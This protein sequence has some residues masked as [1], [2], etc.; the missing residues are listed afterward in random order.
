MVGG[1]LSAIVP[2][3][4]YPFRRI[5]LAR[6]DLNGTAG[7]LMSNKYHVYLLLDPQIVSDKWQERVFYVGKGTGARA[8]SHDLET[9]ESEKVDR[10]NHIRDA[11]R[12]YDILYA[13]WTDRTGME[14][15]LMS[16]REAFQ[17]EAALIEALRPQLTNKA[18][19]HNLTFITATTL[20]TL[21]EARLVNIPSEI[22]ALIVSVMGIRG[23]ADVLGSFVSPDPDFAWENA[24]R[25]WDFGKY[26]QTQ[27]SDQLVDNEPVALIAVTSTRHAHP[28]IVVGVYQIDSFS[29]EKPP[30][31]KGKLKVVFERKIQEEEHHQITEL[32]RDLL[33]NVLCINDRPMVLRQRRI[34]H[35]S[36][37]AA[38]YSRFAK[39]IGPK[40][41]K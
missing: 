17:L 23:G 3:N 30:R 33:G 27:L 10:I 19:G 24:R 11:G 21:R 1:L 5:L 32:R 9:G 18:A 36:L 2:L 37:E 15:T 38:G 4:C 39:K 22:N 14:P 26:T 34:S 13:C 35:A 12:T 8:L 29:L 31:N 25:W 28:N 16:E 6:T 7:G 41:P 20:D 40:F